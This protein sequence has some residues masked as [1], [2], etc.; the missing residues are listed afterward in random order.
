MKIENPTKTAL[1]DLAE[2]I[3]QT[4]SFANVSFQT[5]ADGVGIKKGSVY[6]H[7]ESKDQLAEALIDRTRHRLRDA[8]QQIV[9]EPPPKQ[10]RI[11]INWFLRNIGAAE[12]MCPGAN[13]A[14]CWDAL[15]VSTREKVKHLYATHQSGL[16]AIIE[17]G[18]AQRVFGTALPAKTL[19]EAIFALL[20]G[21]LLSSRVAEDPKQ[22]EA[23]KTTALQLVET[24]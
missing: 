2:E 14:V 23:V 5:L 20:Q 11:Y 16:K 19:A 12:K 4:Q 21:G 10:L 15:P 18:R 8:L 7:F 13:F 9:N 22:F 24:G 3:L 17:R 6:Y 1:M